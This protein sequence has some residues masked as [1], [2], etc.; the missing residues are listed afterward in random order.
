MADR[1]AYPISIAYCVACSSMQ[2]HLSSI[3]YPQLAP[4]RRQPARTPSHTS[5]TLNHT[6]NPATQNGPYKPLN[7]K[8]SEIRILYVDGFT[9]GSPYGYETQ[10]VTGRLRHTSLDKKHHVSFYA[11]SYVWGDPAP[12]S[13]IILDNGA[14]V[15][16]AHNLLEAL[17]HI[18][19]YRFL[20]VGASLFWQ[21]I[22]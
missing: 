20:P 18:A 17:E 19:E 5:C 7:A 12:V 21:S 16:I 2:R 13:S 22:C 1:D 3:G 6:M 4:R 15:P 9:D 14:R 11:L 10:C 8:N